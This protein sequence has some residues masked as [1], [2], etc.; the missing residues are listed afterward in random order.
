[1]QLCSNAH[2]CMHPWFLIQ[3]DQS[4]LLIIGGIRQIGHE[5]GDYYGSLPL[6]QTKARAFKVWKTLTFVGNGDPFP[7]SGA[8]SW[9]LP[10]FRSLLLPFI[11]CLFFQRTLACLFAPSMYLIHW[12]S[13]EFQTFHWLT[14]IM[15]NVS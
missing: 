15:F 4:R 2:Q 13:W 7:V 10:Y 14:F 8:N 6:Q 5:L 1:M 11:I 12:I 9:I 3:N